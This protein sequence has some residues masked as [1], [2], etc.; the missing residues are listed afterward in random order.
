MKSSHSLRKGDRLVVEIESLAGGGEGV[1][2]VDGLPIFVSRVAPGDRVEIELFDVRKNFAFGKSVNLIEPAAMRDDAPCKL[3]KVCGGCH[4]QH[5]GYPHQVDQKTSLVRQAILH[6]GGLDDSVV[7]PALPATEPL[8]YRNKVQFPVSSPLRSSR[9]LAGYYKEGSHELVNIKHCPIQPEPLDRMLEC[10]K[11]A[12]EKHGMS[13]Y[14]EEDHFGSVRH[15]TAR[16]SF[17]YNE[18]LVTIVVN[19]AAPGAKKT[20]DGMERVAKEL[21][22]AVPEITGVCLN[23]NPAR[24]NRIFGNDF[25]V[26][27]GKGHLR[28]RL[29]SARESAHLLHKNGIEFL[30]T[31]ASFFQV[32]TRQSEKLLELVADVIQ[33]KCATPVGLIV[34]AYG[35]VGTIAMWLSPYAGKLVC[36]EE[37]EA[38]VKDG[39]AIAA[40][41]SI[42]NVVFNKG[43]VEDWLPSYA[44]KERIDVVV[45]DPPR[46]GLAA[47]VIDTICSSAAP[48]VIY[49]SCNPATL[50][51]DLKIFAVKGYKTESIQPVDM[52]P[53][54]HHVESIAVLIRA[55]DG[56]VSED[57]Q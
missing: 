53:Q 14:R 24:G 33:A 20:L 21:M 27:A 25:I 4:W 56:P 28:E 46:K 39:I 36:I 30:L 42:E 2:K 54:T 38:A 44:E 35:G 26:L 49:V 19:E 23:F 47:T 31:P 15:I 5:I 45:V 22:A 51:R 11:V 37:V 34:D 32:N 13:A 7:L 6:I 52:F 10:T 41:N 1:A 50:A 3:F 29:C 55:S 48:L 12:L 16:Y 43:R 9:I 17:A 18:V 40:A 8:Y 57:V